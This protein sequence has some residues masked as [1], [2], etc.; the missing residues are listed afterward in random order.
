M[1]KRIK[2][3]EA[4]LKIACEGLTVPPITHVADD[5][6]GE[7]IHF[8]VEAWSTWKYS[9]RKSD[10]MFI[11]EGTA[12]DGKGISETLL[13]SRIVDEQAR[14]HAF[15]TAY[16]AAVIEAKGNSRRVVILNRDEAKMLV[17]D[18]TV[19]HANPNE[20]Y[21]QVWVKDKPT[22]CTW[23]A[24]SAQDAANTTAHWY[25]KT[26]ITKIST[27]TKEDWERKYKQSI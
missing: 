19:A 21:F 13:V 17:V 9:L 12:L 18:E 11:R 8:N 26:S 2:A 4:G 3:L 20:V 14:H 16:E 22:P 6:D 25:D 5:D 10:G 23:M 24:F 15:V 1:D 27:I 7:F